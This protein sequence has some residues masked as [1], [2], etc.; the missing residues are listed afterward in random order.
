MKVLGVN[1]FYYLRGGSETYFFSL[2]QLL[3]E[4]GYEIIPISMKDERNISNRFE[5][6]FIEHIDYTNMNITEKITNSFKLI[7][8]VE[9]YEKIKKIVREQKPQIA[10]L[11]IFQHQFSPSI[12]HA[13]KKCKIPIVN[14][15]HDLKVICPNYQML[16]QTGICEKCKGSKYYNCFKYSC[17]KDSKIN[18]LVYVL[19]AYLHKILKSYS[20]VDKYICPSNFYKT[21]LCEFGIKPEKVVHVPNFVD[22]NAFI[23]HYEF[24]NYFLYVG[25]IAEEKGLM[26]LIK[27]MKF[28]NKSSLILVG[29]G[30]YE[31]EL[32]NEVANLN[33]NNVKFVGYKT[34]DDLRG[35]IQK[36]K[37]L[38]LPSEWYEN[39][40]M[41]II[42]AMAY[43][44]AVIGSDLGGIPELI[45]DNVTGSVFEAGNAE[46]LAG[47]INY[48]L[49]NEN[50]LIN[51]G[52]EARKRAEKLYDKKTHFEQIK[53]IY[54]ECVD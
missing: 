51:M 34:G 32:Q 17:A 1:K 50:L 24:D 41:S 6:Y 10:H 7:Y 37:F 36:C 43:G 18:S 47:K 13:L 20:L 42:E 23:P 12:L 54:Q 49:Q 21:K 2:N 25:R 19:E 15:V 11:H 44:K 22:V 30:P 40:P 9:A 38:I 46:D 35:I 27:A 29:T 14:T 53:N 45:A 26:T 16:N 5:K 52:R 31:K 33:I 39:C 3:E 48:Y 8:S 4:N 28:V